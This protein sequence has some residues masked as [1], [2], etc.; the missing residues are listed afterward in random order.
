MKVR[1]FWPIDFDRPFASTDFLTG[2]PDV[3]VT[4]QGRLRAYSSTFLLRFAQGSRFSRFQA[5]FA[6]FA[7]NLQHLAHGVVQAPEVI[8]KATGDSVTGS[9]A[10]SSFPC[11]RGSSSGTYEE[12]REQLSQPVHGEGHVEL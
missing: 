9:I 5:A 3:N 1:I 2:F 6:S 8:F 7:H 10:R 11:T 4:L 12:K